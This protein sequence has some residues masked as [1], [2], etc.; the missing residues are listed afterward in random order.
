MSTFLQ[1]GYIA[2]AAAMGLN[3]IYNMPYLERLAKEQDILFLP[4][5]EAKY[6][7][8]GK[9]Y[10]AY[11]NAVVGT[12]SV[13]GEIA[14]WLTQAL[15]A[16]PELTKEQYQE[17]LFEHIKPGGPYV[18]YVESYGKQLVINKLAEQVKGNLPALEINDDQMVGLIPYWVCKDRGESS[19]RAFELAQAFTSIHDFLDVYKMLDQL[20]EDIPTQG[21][22]QAIKQASKLAPKS[23][24]IPVQKAMDVENTMEFI[25]NHS[26][27]ACHIPHAI[28]LILHILYHTDSFESALQK[29]TVI[30]GASCDRGLTI[31]A[32]AGLAYPVPTDWLRYGQ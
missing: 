24:K 11:P 10:L 1:H 7:R 2:N 27:T 25:T 23:M 5:D 14:K 17:L 21:M 26:G 12:I 22:R 15:D 31:G 9:A 16:N 13:Q 20:I 4:V 6:K 19:E 30:G 3:W 28:P 29:N 32:L 8:A 18:G